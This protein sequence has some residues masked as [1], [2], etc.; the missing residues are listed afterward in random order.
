MNVDLNVDNSIPE[1]IKTYLLSRGLTESVLARNHITW[2]GERI[3]I[4]V[5][6]PSGYWLFNKYRRDPDSTV[7]PKY[8][9][10][11]GA[12]SALYGADKI[13]DAKR[14]IMCEGE[15]DALMLEA[16]G[17]EAVSST[18]GAGTFSEEWLPLFEG[19][20]VFL[21]YD[22]DEAGEKGRVR[23][24]KLLPAVRHVFLPHE[25]GDHGDITD[26][27]VKLGKTKKDFD[28][29]LSVAQ[30][31]VLPPEPKPVRR[32]GNSG[33]KSDRLRTAKEVPLSRILKFNGQ[34]FARCPF[35]RDTTPS[36][37]WFGQNKWK[38]FGCGDT[39]D[40]IDLVM[41]MQN[42]PMKEAITFLLSL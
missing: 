24:A 42:I 19:K 35:H 22:N 15:F 14:V 34:K 31:L 1:R 40:G 12:K 17:Y 5:F 6:E 41:R 29:L 26:F 18:G 8:T 20:E 33:V 7:G 25:V 21:C 37:H 16:V 9:Y 11:K 23:I 39:G 13:R 10:D 28:I 30:P 38:C 32:K 4:P 3:V 27:F 36:L 2:D